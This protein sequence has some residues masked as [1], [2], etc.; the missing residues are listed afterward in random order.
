V[1]TCV[2]NQS[3]GYYLLNDAL[4]LAT[5]MNLKCKEETSSPQFIENWMEDD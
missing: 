5:T 1:T 4:H 2:L 3:H